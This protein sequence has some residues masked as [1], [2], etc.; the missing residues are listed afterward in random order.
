MLHPA[1]ASTILMTTTRTATSTRVRTMKCKRNSSI[2][3]CHC[4]IIITEPA[5]TPVQCLRT[6]PL[7]FYLSLLSRSWSQSP[8]SSW[9]FFIFVCVTIIKC[10]LLTNNK[11]DQPYKHYL[12][13][14]AVECKIPISRFWNTLYKYQKQ[15]LLP[16]IAFPVTHKHTSNTL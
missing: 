5:S 4:L 8:P 7:L 6:L 9:P 13:P 14:G 15:R 16:L 2:N 1:A 11:K 10:S 3:H 12:K